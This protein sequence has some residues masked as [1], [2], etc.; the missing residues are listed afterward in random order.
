MVKQ[1]KWNSYQFD[2]CKRFLFLIRSYLA[3]PAG[4]NQNTWMRF[5][6]CRVGQSPTTVSWH[7]PRQ[8]SSSVQS[9]AE[10]CQR[11][12]KRREVASLPLASKAS[13]PLKRK[14][15]GQLTFD[16]WRFSWS[17]RLPFQL[18][19]SITGQIRHASVAFLPSQPLISWTASQC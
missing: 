10:S 9:P 14:R 15:L 5:G 6:S 2:R 11:P 13:L 16:T 18:A 17:G 8:A 3:R 7:Y 1:V 12:F 4:V 19:I